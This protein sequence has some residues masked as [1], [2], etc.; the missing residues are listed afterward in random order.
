MNDYKNINKYKQKKKGNKVKTH[1]NSKSSIINKIINT[2]LK[3]NL[4]NTININY[5][6]LH[7]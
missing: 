7:K 3:K 2:K 1:I 4:S 6:L 5:N